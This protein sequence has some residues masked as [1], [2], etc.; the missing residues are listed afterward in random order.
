MS[1]KQIVG[2]LILSQC[3]TCWYIFADVVSALQSSNIS[4]SYILSLKMYIIEKYFI[5][6]E[7]FDP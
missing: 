6:H 5:A 7:I 3:L 2:K 1:V 4:P